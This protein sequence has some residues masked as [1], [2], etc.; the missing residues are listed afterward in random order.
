MT[1]VEAV[2]EKYRVPVGARTGAAID[3]P[4]A[5]ETCHGEGEF[6]CVRECHVIDCP[7]C[8]GTGDRA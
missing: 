5:C 2:A 1:A 7:E 8:E 6:A 3:D 4:D